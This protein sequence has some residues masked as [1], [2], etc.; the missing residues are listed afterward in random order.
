M[1]AEPTHFSVLLTGQLECAEVRARAFCQRKLSIPRAR[2]LMASTAAAAAG[3]A[4]AALP[5]AHTHKTPPLPHNKD[6]G[7]RQRVLQ[8]RARCGRGLGAARRRVA[9]AHT[10]RARGASPRR[11]V[12]LLLA[13][14]RLEPPARRGVALDQRGGLAAGRGVRVRRRRPRARRAARLRRD[15]R[16]DVP[17]AVRSDG[18][19]GCSLLRP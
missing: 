18:V 2:A 11:R 3:A 7:R 17:R 5:R 1:A 4:A 14:T 8:V 6:P 12:I 15:A 10:E 19:A 9:R 16:A 13:A